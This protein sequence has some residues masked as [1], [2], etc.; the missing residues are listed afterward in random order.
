MLSFLPLVVH[1]EVKISPRIL[2]K[3]ERAHNVQHC[4]DGGYMPPFFF[5]LVFVHST[6]HTLYKSVRLTMNCYET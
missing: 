4:K 2:E 6:G 1:L 3:I 5:L